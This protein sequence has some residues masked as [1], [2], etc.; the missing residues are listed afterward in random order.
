[1]PQPCLTIRFHGHACISASYG[2]LVIV[3]DPHDGLSL[4][5]PTPNVKGDVVLV[6]HDHFDHN[7]VSVVAGPGAQVLES[8]VGTKELSVKGKRISVEG[9]RVP[10]DKQSGKRRGW[11]SAYK[12]SVDGFVLLHLGDIGDIPGES[13][14][15]RMREPRPHALFIPVGGF[16]TVEPYEAWEIASNINPIYLVPIHYWVRGVN[17]PIKPIQDFLLA[18][19]SGREERDELV[20]CRGEEEPAKPKIVVLRIV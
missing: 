16:Y 10:H 5:L 8:F 3:F 18:A 6:T 17:L 7:A 9:I 11:V 13:E 2:D 14:L 1:L 4:G 12:V 19:K 15:K 20:I